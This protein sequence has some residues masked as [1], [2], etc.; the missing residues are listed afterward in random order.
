MAITKATNRPNRLDPAS[1]AA[2]TEP[3]CKRKLQDAGTRFEPP[4]RILIR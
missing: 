3:T 1:Y 2:L 4:N